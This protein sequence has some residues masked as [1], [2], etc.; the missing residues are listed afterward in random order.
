MPAAGSLI[1]F[2]AE[3][4]FGLTDLEA[5]EEYTPDFA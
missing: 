1:D 5:F 3:F 4:V 2:G